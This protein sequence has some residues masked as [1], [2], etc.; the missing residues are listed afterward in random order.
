MKRKKF[1]VWGPKT[2][3]KKT[4]AEICI[5]DK[6]LGK[7]LQYTV[8]SKDNDGFTY[9]Y[10]KNAIITTVL[11]VPAIEKDKIAFIDKHKTLNNIPNIAYAKSKNRRHF[12][13]VFDVNNIL[14]F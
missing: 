1:K 6:I 9:D 7:E 10:L 14:E 11:E 5:E 13:I 8:I 3:L 4:I 2:E 12:D